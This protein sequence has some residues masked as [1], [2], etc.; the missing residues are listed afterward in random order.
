MSEIKLAKSNK[1]SGRMA[2]SALRQR[3]D[4]RTQLR[5]HPPEDVLC[6]NTSDVMKPVG[7][8]EQKQTELVNQLCDEPSQ[9]SPY[10]FHP[11]ADTRQQPQKTDFYYPTPFSAEFGTNHSQPEE[12]PI[13]VERFTSVRSDKTNEQSSALLLKKAGQKSKT[14]RMLNDNPNHEI[15][16]DVLLNRSE[17]GNADML[18]GADRNAATARTAASS[19]SRFLRQG[20]K[21][22]LKLG[23]RAA[24]SAVISSQVTEKME[25]SDTDAQKVLQQYEKSVRGVRS[26]SRS[27]QNRKRKQAEKRAAQAGRFAG[28]AATD[29]AGKAAQQGG[30]KLATVAAE[31]IKETA[32]SIA[33]F[34]GSAIVPV[35][36]VILSILLVVMIFMSMFTS[37]AGS[38]Y[39]IFFVH[40][41]Q[42]NMEF[43]TAVSKVTNSYY[44]KIYE[45]EMSKD[46]E[47]VEAS[48]A[49]TDSEEVWK[50]IT[51]IYAVDVCKEGLDAMTMDKEHYEILE[52]VFWQ[53]VSVSFWD[54]SWT[55]RVETEVSPAHTETV[56][57]T[58]P[59]TGA[60]TITQVNIPAE[61]EVTYVVHRTLHITVSAKTLDQ[62]KNRYGFTDGEKQTVD[63]LL[64]E[65][66][67][68]WSSLT[69]DFTNLII[70]S[71]SEEG[72]TVGAVDVTAYSTVAETV[73]RALIEHGYSKQAACGILGN[74]QQECS[75]NPDCQ[76][77]GA[78]GMCQWM[79][80]RLEN[81][82]Q[83]SGYQTVSVQTSFM[84]GEL[85][86]QTSIWSTYGS[87]VN[88]TYNGVKITS[89]SAF[90][91]CTNVKAAAGAFC[92][93][94]ERSGEFPGNQWY[95][96]RLNYAQQWYSY[97]QSHWVD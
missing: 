15:A 44:N 32:A 97:A 26:L 84:I 42:Q 52:D 83:R 86:S 76:S 65:G 9:S 74:I 54:S 5:K 73:Y 89:L 11:Q 72:G 18:L 51:A 48:C 1:D 13:Q 39:G 61:M 41:Q 31:T 29:T 64:A 60:V 77:G 21:S 91:N 59:V 34:A 87:E 20:S 88:H 12:Q 33:A 23:A 27:I 94:F 2:D 19:A 69:P 43:D 78:Y 22:L 10:R 57:T 38:P 55:E 3:R 95:E 53:K 49:I 36:A 46:Y 30:K 17:A 66:D 93:C 81:L 50:E 56:T 70:S 68:L 7:T 67:D 63:D 16:P 62:M 45:Q 85:S 14:D 75:M 24:A 8:V 40:E 4:E 71:N 47:E 80:S 37:I 28:R 79:G 35:L 58:D 92:I 6:D 96:A 82:K 25:D 90:K